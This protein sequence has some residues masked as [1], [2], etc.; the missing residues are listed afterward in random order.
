MRAEN[1][2]PVKAISK[3]AEVRDDDAVGNGRRQEIGD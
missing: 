1:E 3:D 2:I